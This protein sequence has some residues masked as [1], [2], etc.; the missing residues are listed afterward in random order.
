MDRFR[1]CWRIAKWK[2]WPQRLEEQPGLRDDKAHSNVARSSS[3][4]ACC[5]PTAL[6]KHGAWHMSS[7]ERVLHEDDPGVTVEILRGIKFMSPRPAPAHADVVGQLHFE[8]ETAFGWRRMRKGGSGEGSGWVFLPEPE[9][10][11]EGAGKPLVPDLAGWRKERLPMIPRK[12]AFTLAPDWACEVLSE[13][14]ASIDRRFKLPIY[15]EAGVSHVW[16]VDPI[17]QTLE[18]FQRGPS[19]WLLL[20]TFGGDSKVRPEPF[21]AVELDLADIWPPL[22]PLAP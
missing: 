22:E 6:R 18:V 21:S 19:A 7:V 4:V 11:L 17:L 3:G 12:A 20:G 14:T 2:T 9:L 8:L 5:E 16:L 15:H 10:H 1:A 13:R